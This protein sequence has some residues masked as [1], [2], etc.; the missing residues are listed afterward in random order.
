M[1]YNIPKIVEEHGGKEKI[2]YLIEK[3]CYTYPMLN[4]Y[5]GLNVDRRILKNILNYCEATIPYPKANRLSRVFMVKYDNCKDNYWND[6]AFVS[7]LKERLSK[8]ILNKA[9]NHKRY[10]ISFP[11]HPRANPDSNQVKA[12]IIVWELIN[13][14]YLIQGQE[15]YPIDNNYLNLEPINWLTRTETDRK[16]YHSTGD[17][18]HFYKGVDTHGNY[19]YGWKRISKQ[20]KEINPVCN[21]CNSVEDLI[22]HHILDYR[23]H[24]SIHNYE[25]LITLCR[26]CH[27]KVHNNIALPL[28]DES[29]YEKLLKLLETLN[30]ET[31]SSQDY[32][33]SKVQRLSERSR[34]Q[35][36]SKRGAP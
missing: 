7:L 27:G 17:K 25:N 1:A 22:V 8:P 16:S 11:N 5:L 9:G 30:I 21:I 32:L 13:K 3:E 12:H 35:E 33:C 18:N 2:K 6:E 29:Q 10:V 20:F 34:G 14:K 15:A 31:I 26:P 23:E 24:P 28:I 19:K 4:E 36:A